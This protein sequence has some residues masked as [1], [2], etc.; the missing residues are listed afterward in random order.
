MKEHKLN[1]K[2][3]NILTISLCEKGQSRRKKDA[4]MLECSAGL[5][6]V[7]LAKEDMVVRKKTSFDLNNVGMQK[8]VEV[9]AVLKEG[10][11]EEEDEDSEDE[12]E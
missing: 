9:F 12:K 11:P 3:F 1:L 5:V 8:T 10:D 7:D 6:D 4:Q 2:I